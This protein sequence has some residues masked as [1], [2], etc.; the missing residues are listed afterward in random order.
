MNVRGAGERGKQKLGVTEDASLSSMFKE[1]GSFNGV[2]H[3][4]ISTVVVAYHQIM[5]KVAISNE[6][7]KLH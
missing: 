6:P 7:I 4:L 1:E 3:L 2:H 5:V